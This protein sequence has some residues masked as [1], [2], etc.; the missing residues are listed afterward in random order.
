MKIPAILQDYLESTEQNAN[1]MSKKRLLAEA[2][3]IAS[4]E[5]NWIALRDEWGEVVEDYEYTPQQIG[6]LTRFINRLRQEV[7]EKG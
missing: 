3:Y 2:E 1:K 5:G 4:P 6:A 7:F